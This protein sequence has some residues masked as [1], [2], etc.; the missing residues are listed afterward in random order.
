MFA[1]DL[2]SRQWIDLG[3]V[4]P[5]GLECSTVTVLNNSHPCAWGH[6]QI[7]SKHALFGSHLKKKKLL[8]TFHRLQSDSNSDIML[9][10]SVRLCLHPRLFLT[11]GLWQEIPV[12]WWCWWRSSSPGW[13]WWDPLTLSC[14]SQTQCPRLH[15]VSH[16]LQRTTHNAKIWRPVQVYSHYD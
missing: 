8:L 15:S 4:E 13:S 14:Q 6:K 16:S 5:D 7:M 10:T 3:V 12:C 9:Q 2:K 1:W 11:E